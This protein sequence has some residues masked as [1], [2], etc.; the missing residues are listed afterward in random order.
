MNTR[1]M[2]ALRRTALVLL[3]AAAGACGGD[4]RDVALDV[5]AVAFA[6]GQVLITVRNVG[7]LMGTLRGCPDG[8]MTVIERWDGSGW[9]TYGTRN[10]DC[11]P[12]QT[13][14]YELAAGQSIDFELELPEGR[15]RFSLTL[16]VEGRFGE[17]TGRSAAV[18][19]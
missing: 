12:S 7:N 8:P 16:V 9:T 1:P 3:L 18:D 10:E 14:F 19:V 11:L 6:P 13:V 2:R 17:G 4:D 15:Y 5:E